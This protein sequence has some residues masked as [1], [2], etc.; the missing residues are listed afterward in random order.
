M[1]VISYKIDSLFPSCLLASFSIKDSW[2][3][4]WDSNNLPEI[5]TL[6][7]VICYLPS[8]MN[9]TFLAYLFSSSNFLSLHT[10][11]I[12]QRDLFKWILFCWSLV[13]LHWCVNFCYKAKWFINTHMH[14]HVYHFLYSFLLWLITGYWIQ[15]PVLYCRTL[16]FIHFIHNSL[17][18]IIPNSKQIPSQPSLPL[19]NCK[20]IVYVYES[21]LQI[22]S[23]CHMNFRLHI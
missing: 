8:E 1:K 22:N 23:L 12:L 13:D 16:L 11:W 18:L 19:A 6:K 15:F 20:S 14:T 10:G 3:E 17:H 21:V 9:S 7:F 4:K 2:P 5:L